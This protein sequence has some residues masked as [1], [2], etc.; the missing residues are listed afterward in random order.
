[1]AERVIIGCVYDDYDGQY[2]IHVGKGFTSIRHCGSSLAPDDGSGG[3]W[4]SHR[5]LKESSP[6]FI[7]LSVI[8]TDIQHAYLIELPNGGFTYV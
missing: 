6:E 5:Y 7:K 3:A 2:E 4:L 8:D 1:M